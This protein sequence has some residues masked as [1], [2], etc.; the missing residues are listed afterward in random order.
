MMTARE[1]V[2]LIK[3][4]TVLPWND[5]STRDQF[6]VGNPISQSRVSPPP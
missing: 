5:R 1:V 4:N 6:K 2:D 3:K